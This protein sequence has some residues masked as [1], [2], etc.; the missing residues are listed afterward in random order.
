[1]YENTS[2][3]F[4]NN[5]QILYFQTSEKLLSTDDDL[6]SNLGYHTIQII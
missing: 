1:M 4:K 5:D 2:T 6:T 3:I